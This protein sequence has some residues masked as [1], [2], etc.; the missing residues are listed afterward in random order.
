MQRDPTCRAFGFQSCALGVF[1]V[2]CGGRQPGEY[3][4]E[5]FLAAY[6]VA[7]ELV[8]DFEAAICGVGN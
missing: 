8:D 2:G 1:G 5:D 4:G 7:V 3:G 6:G